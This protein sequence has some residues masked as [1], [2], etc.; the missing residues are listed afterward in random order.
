MQPDTGNRSFVATGYVVPAELHIDWTEPTDQAAIFAKAGIGD[1]TLVH[2]SLYHDTL[3][4]GAL[5]GDSVLDNF[6]DLTE[7]V[8]VAELTKVETDP[9][10]SS[11]GDN[12]FR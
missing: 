5:I 6:G 2:Q 1:T 3:T 4:E 8:T 11:E 12:Y 7:G 10:P 9:A